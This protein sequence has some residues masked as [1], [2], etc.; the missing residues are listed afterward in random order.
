MKIRPKYRL[1]HLEKGWFAQTHVKD[2]FSN[3]WYTIAPKTL[4]LYS[5]E[6]IQYPVNTKEEALEVIDKYKEELK[7]SRNVEYIYLGVK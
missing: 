3:G 2:Q 1:K 7:A 6:D 5:E 4:G